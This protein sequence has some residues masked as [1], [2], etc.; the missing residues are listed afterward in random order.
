MW[1]IA[2]IR[3]RLNDSKGGK[4]M[5]KTACIILSILLLSVLVACQNEEV[6]ETNNAS[7]ENTLSTENTAP[8]ENTS[9]TENVSLYNSYV[10]DANDL[11][12]CSIEKKWW[13]YSMLENN[14]AESPK[15]VYY[16]GEAIEVEYEY[17]SFGSYSKYIVDYYCS[18]DF[19]F[20]FRSSDRK[21]VAM[22]R[23]T[24]LFD[25]AYSQQED[26]D[27]AYSFARET[28]YAF[29]EKYADLSQYQ[30]L[31]YTETHE[32]DDKEVVLYCFCF[33]KY[34][35][36]YET[37]DYIYIQITSKGDVR[38]WGIGDTGLFDSV[39]QMTIDEKA[40]E[41]SIK[42]KMRALY[43]SKGEYSYHVQTQVMAYTPDGQL[44]MISRI[45]VKVQ[46]NDGVSY[47]ALVILGT[48][49][50]QS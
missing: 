20:Y 13:P 26:M 49:M 8:T 24:L 30:L 46:T 23:P 40:L 35:D 38:E 19:Q 32:G 10:V 11:L 6:Q 17:S 25:D 5:K 28:A 15:T 39:Q 3:I 18:K 45:A 43:V 29:A 16:E 4:A 41:E 9:P 7:T 42:N 27:N 48:E 50:M 34:I 44:V 12:G 14:D 31:E 1:L 47:S 33:I 2:A 36:G 22:R 21:M 37:N